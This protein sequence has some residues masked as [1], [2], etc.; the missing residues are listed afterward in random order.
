MNARPQRLH[1]Y[2]YADLLSSI[3]CAEK[4]AWIHDF[5]SLRFI[6][7]IHDSRKQMKILVIGSGGREHALV[8]ALRHTCTRPSEIFCAPGNAGI[9]QEAECVNIAATDISAL[10]D[11]AE[12]KGID[13]TMVGPE[14]PLASGIVDEF[15][16]RCLRMVGP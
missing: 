5:L 12:E 14:A 9:A 16:R 2:D 7:R 10:A 4:D 15:T 11:F 13:L 1:L 3:F 8:W 6:D